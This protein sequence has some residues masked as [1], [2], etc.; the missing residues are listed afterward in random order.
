MDIIARAWT[1]TARRADRGEDLSEMA[2]LAN[3]A[4]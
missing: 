3:L 2:P 1:M 4:A